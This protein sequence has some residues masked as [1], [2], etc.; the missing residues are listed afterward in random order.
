MKLSIKSIQEKIK[1]QEMA[2]VAKE[3]EA[4]ELKKLEQAKSRQKTKFINQLSEK[5]LNAALEGENE[6]QVGI[7]C[8]SDIYEISH[9]LDEKFL[10]VREIDYEVYLEN[11]IKDYLNSLDEGQLENIINLLIKSRREL[12][13]I[14]VQIV[15]A[16]PEI[17]AEG[18]LDTADSFLD[19]F[20]GDA[21]LEEQIKTINLVC[22][23]IQ[24]VID[25]GY[26]VECWEAYS[27]VVDELSSAVKNLWLF[28]GADKES[29]VFFIKWDV[30]ED[31]DVLNYEPIDEYFNSLGLA[32]ISGTHGQ[33]LVAALMD[34]V[35]KKI[36]SNLTSLKI[37]LYKFS[38]G[39]RIELENK[40]EVYTLL[41][42]VGLTRLFVKLGYK[43]R[44]SERASEDIVDI[45]ISWA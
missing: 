23:E 16:H 2:K 28:N 38:S 44:C 1:A 18:M 26:E 43:V 35:D 13:D 22:L 15:K 32:W 24:D 10:E 3:K 42:E 27:D 8:G 41:D 36:E 37:C 45:E 30:L 39:Y 31:D 4:A 11:Q 29:Q 19:F 33:L 9:F 5:I 17:Y 21:S 12:Q 34:L 6:V 14:C 40:S 20:N 7:D 25:E